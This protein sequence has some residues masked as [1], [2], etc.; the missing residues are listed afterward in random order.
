MKGFTFY[1]SY[2]DVAQ[3]LETP[4]EQGE[5]Y[6]AIA[7]YMFANK[8]REAEL[9]WHVRV[10]FKAVKANLKTSKK[11]A[12]A[13]AKREQIES[14]TQSNGN[15]NAIKRQSKR[16]QDKVQVQGQGQG[17][18][19]NQ[20]DFH[21]SPPSDSIAATA[22]AAA[23]ESLDVSFPCPYCGGSAEGTWNTG[24]GKYSA[25]CSDPLCGADFAITAEAVSMAVKGAAS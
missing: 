4:E 12:K 21:P 2:F 23:P 1:I 8:D 11:R 9:S 22:G 24:M 18:G 6:R 13:A 16:Q 7:D 25:R 10:C 14:K 17:E 15:Q 19:E 3:E 20:L 5:F